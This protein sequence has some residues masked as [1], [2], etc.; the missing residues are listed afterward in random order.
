MRPQSPDEADYRF[1]TAQ[2]ASID[3][4]LADT[5]EG[6]ELPLFGNRAGLLSLANVLLWFVANSWRREFL[7]LTDLPFVRA[8]GLRSLYLRLSHEEGTG[9]DG[10]RARTDCGQQ[11]EWT[12]PEEDLRR[13]ALSVH[14]LA[15]KPSHQYD[16]LLPAEP[17]AVGIQICMTDAAA[18]LQRG[19]A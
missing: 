9:R 2:G 4:A 17:S 18:W 19:N 3:M 15:S 10:F 6:G 1:L 14:R 13:M 16:R 8:Q 5:A 11:F 7:T 12:I